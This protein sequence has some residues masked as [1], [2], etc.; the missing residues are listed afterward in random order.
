MLRKLK[1]YLKFANSRSSNVLPATVT[2][3]RPCATVTVSRPCATVTVS[4]PC[5]TVTVSRLLL[6]LQN[7]HFKESRGGSRIL[8]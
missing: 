7:L 6:Q 4:R 1:S 2:V 5:A 8:S 3:S